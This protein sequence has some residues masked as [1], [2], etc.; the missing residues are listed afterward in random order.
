MWKRPRGEVLPV[1]RS[2]CSS[3]PSLSPNPW[4]CLLLPH[5]LFL[6][7]FDE[8]LEA[9]ILQ[10]AKDCEETHAIMFSGLE[11]KLKDASVIAGLASASLSERFEPG[12]HE[13]VS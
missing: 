6:F 8:S 4:L 1:Y 7:V 3:P 5:S 13:P 10:E 11:E 2:L 9:A 12:L